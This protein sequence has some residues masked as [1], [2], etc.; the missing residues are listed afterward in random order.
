MIRPQAVN[1][2]RVH[3]T[4]PFSCILL[5]RQCFTSFLLLPLHALIMSTQLALW[6]RIRINTFPRQIIPHSNQDLSPDPGHFAVNV[7]H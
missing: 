5:M 6:H 1:A 3:T 2:D 4:L 7:P